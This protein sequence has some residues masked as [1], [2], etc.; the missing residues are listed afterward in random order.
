VEAIESP[1]VSAR[2]APFKSLR[3]V[4]LAGVAALALSACANKRPT[5]MA[6]A[7]FS[8]A[9]ATQQASA[10][11]QLAARYKS[12]PRDKATIIYYAA[13][14]RSAGQADQAARVMEDGLGLYKNDADIKVAYAKAL[15]AAGRFDQA[16][17]VVDGAI[18]PAQP[19]WNALR[20]KGAILDQSARND[21]ARTLYTQALL[22]A[23]NEASLE[24]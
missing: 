8:G 6:S 12:N 1:P 19:N 13:A 11:G 10:V 5:G 17:N 2:I 3:I 4:L 22:G 24:A 18:D 14:P 21:E 7:D 15:S 16:L 23:P 9:T 20:V